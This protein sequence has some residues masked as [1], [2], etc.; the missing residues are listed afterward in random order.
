MGKGKYAEYTDIIF[1]EG[2]DIDLRG[3]G[4][5]IKDTFEDEI[6]DVFIRLFDFCGHRKIDIEKFIQLKMK[7]NESREKMHGKKY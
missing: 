5:H 2:S 4:I 1:N 3:F 7:Y 6:A